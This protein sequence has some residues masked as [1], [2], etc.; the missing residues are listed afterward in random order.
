MVNGFLKI[1]KGI[2]TA[3]QALLIALGGTDA[4][5]SNALAEVLRCKTS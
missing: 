5:V 3:G 2:N 1:I 4:A